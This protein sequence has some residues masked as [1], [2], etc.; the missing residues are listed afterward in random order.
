MQLFAVACRLTSEDG[1]AVRKAVRRVGCNVLE[2][3][4]ATM[5]EGR[6]PSGELTFATLGHPPAVAGDRR[7]QARRGDVIVVFNG[8]PVDKEGRFE[9][10]DATTLLE[11]WEI[12]D[13]RLEGMFSALRI[14][15]SCDKVECLLDVLG[16][17]PTF[18]ARQGGGWIVSNSVAVIRSVTGR[19]CP[20]PLGVSSLLSMGWAAGGR[21][22]VAGITR[23]AGGSKYTLSPREW[24]VRTLFTPA[25][26]A[27]SNNS[28]DI[29]DVG[30]LADLLRTS[31]AAAVRSVAPVRC[32]LTAGR[33]SRVILALLQSARA[34]SVR[35]YTSGAEAD[36]DV[37]V[38]RALTDRLG[39]PY[40]LLT[41]TVPA[42]SADW[43]ALTSRFV[44]QTDGMSN[45]FAIADHID[46]AGPV[47]RLSLNLFGAGGEVARSGRVGLLV[48]FAAN[49][50]GFRSSSRVQR[51]VMRAKLGSAEGTVTALSIDTARAHLEDFADTREAEGW[52]PREVL[53]AYYAFERV[54]YW[55]ASGV[56]R[57]AH[58]TDLY[59]PFVSRAFI[60]YA[61]SLSPGER[62][63][64]AAHYDLLSVLAPTLRDMPFD[65]PWRPQQVW[66]APVQA[67]TDLLK[68]AAT[69]LVR[70]RVRLPGRR[71]RGSTPVD[72]AAM[73]FGQR[74]FEAGLSMHRDVCLSSSDSPL[75][76][77][78]DRRR[79]ESAFAASPGQRAPG[80][81]VLCAVATAFWYFH[82][83]GST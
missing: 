31:T 15:L 78:V 65:V 82:G 74:W 83:P 70:D 3:D 41:P 4:A 50:P 39:L 76:A 35:Y 72:G 62:F 52:R 32:P 26:A 27:P 2:L 45:L 11:Q 55:A 8:L 61:F 75:W 59:S 34:E 38:A 24:R 69:R 30:E 12:L 40:E 7:Y 79:L 33:D 46:H 14:D 80:I 51:M 63:I 16:M 9:A 53:E 42:R 43:S 71:S 47:E 1:A 18:V 66:R 21:T 49:T 60:S 17:A 6:S 23:L 5:C 44:A 22:L 73:S 68:A 56:Q 36:T 20:D 67:P 81:G 29:A 19:A 37:R 54:R 28:C 48:P 58:A 77:F 64:E 10:H 25:M 57:M 13:D